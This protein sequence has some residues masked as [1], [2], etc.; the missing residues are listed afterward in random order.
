MAELRRHAFFAGV[1]WA[2]LWAR[3]GPPFAE[4]DLE[5]AGSVSSSFD[6]ELQS[7]AS[8]LPY[9]DPCSVAAARAVSSD[10]VD[11]A[12]EEPASPTC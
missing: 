1:D 3:R 8:A 11:E 9:A 6:W 10:S 5:S 2:G 12:P 7:L 4:P